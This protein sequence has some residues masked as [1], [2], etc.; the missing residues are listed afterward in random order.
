MLRQLAGAVLRGAQR[1]GTQIILTADEQM[2]IKVEG[3]SGRVTGMPSMTFNQ[4]QLDGRTKFL[5]N[6]A[7]QHVL[8]FDLKGKMGKG[9]MPEPR[10]R[11]YVESSHRLI[12]EDVQ[13]KILL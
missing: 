8:F 3:P 9:L 11:V 5:S 1:R 4:D 6:W 12:L 13:K 10:Q 2:Q 7:N